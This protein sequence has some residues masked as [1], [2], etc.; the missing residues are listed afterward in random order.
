[1][2]TN[3]LYNLKIL[4]FKTMKKIISL[5]GLLLFASTGIF[6]AT[7]LKPTNPNT[8]SIKKMVTFSTLPSKRGIEIKL[9]QNTPEKATLIIYNY[10]NDVVWKD[11][12][13]KNKPTQ[14]GFILSQL[15]NGNYTVQVVL[16]KQIVQK[17]AHVYYRG[18]YKYVSL[19]G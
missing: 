18:D 2:S 7:P 3:E 5:T 4:K 16:N 14:K 11:A 9:N 10:E 19:R 8:A 1:M 17:T 15:D 13:G 12:L 6:A